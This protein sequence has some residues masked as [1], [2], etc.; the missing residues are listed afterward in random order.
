MPDGGVIVNITSGAGTR[1]S[2][3]TGPYAAAKA[4]LQAEH[5]I[6][7]I[8][9]TVPRSLIDVAKAV[10]SK[11]SGNEL[12]IDII[13]RETRGRYYRIREGRATITVN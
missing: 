1:G 9:G 10:F 12:N 7:A 3:Y 8:D 6:Q 11:E 13:F 4:G 2:P 5:V